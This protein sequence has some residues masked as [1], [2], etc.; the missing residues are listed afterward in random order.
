MDDVE[1]LYRQLKER[2]GT[3]ARRLK[4]RIHPA[5]FAR[6]LFV[7]RKNIERWN[8]S[9][10]LLRF[11]FFKLSVKLQR[12]FRTTFYDLYLKNIHP[13]FPLAEKALEEGW[14]WQVL[15]VREYN[16]VVFFTD[17][18]RKVQAF[19]ENRSGSGNGF[20]VAEEAYLKLICET[21]LVN[22]L[23]DAFRKIII[24][25]RKESG[26]DRGYVDL[27]LGKLKG[28]LITDTGSRSFLT[29][30]LAHNMA[31]SRRYLVPENLIQPHAGDILPDRFYSCSLEV[32]RKLITRYR[33]VEKEIEELR[34]GVNHLVWLENQSRLKDEGNPEEL[35]AMYNLDANNWGLDGKNYYV[36]FLTLMRGTVKSLERLLR[37]RWNLMS[38]E[39]KIISKKIVNDEGLDSLFEKL[40][41]Q[42]A[43]AEG[44]YRAA[45]PTSIS[46]AEYRDGTIP[47]AI[48]RTKSYGEVQSHFSEMLSS[49]FLIALSLEELSMDRSYPGTFLLRHMIVGPIEYRGKSVLDLFSESIA[50][51][52]RICRYFYCEDLL[53]QLD[54]SSQ[55]RRQLS[56]KVREKN[57]IDANRILESMLGV[58]EDQESPHAG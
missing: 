14:Q 29:F 41:R 35:I 13:L 51:L 46:L 10:N 56:N 42:Y 45:A 12:D 38:T 31:I 9:A 37:Q 57:H 19:G 3:S 43:L 21:G 33:H 24:H 55:V 17:F 8:R 40:A 52:L 5:G 11:G 39:E 49:L 6:Y 7:E 23:A 48:L 4:A 18:C 50:A 25:V 15:S 36:L 58:A 28:Y 53:S 47:D 27:A 22:L 34:K 30:S 54:N 44:C 2:T 1:V 20:A 26:A 16:V 32:F